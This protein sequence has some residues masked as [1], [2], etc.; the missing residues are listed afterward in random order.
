MLNATAAKK[1]SRNWQQRAAWCLNSDVLYPA[2]MR[3]DRLHFRGAE[4][5][6]GEH[7]I[8]V[9]PLMKAYSVAA[10]SI[11]LVFIFGF[12]PPARAQQVD[13]K[14]L[15]EMQWRNVGP[16]RG[17]RTRAVSGVASQ[18]NVFYVGAVN[19]GVWKRTTLD[20]HGSRFS[21][22]NRPAQLARLKSRLPIREL[23]MSAA[24]KDCIVPICQ[25]A[26][27]FI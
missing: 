23:F 2:R 27:E 5:R 14:L 19:G 7:D 18:P 8:E 1:A 16:F 20:A 13:T 25:S 24:A 6:P 9:D 26:M 4:S 21:T 11:L 10:S 3:C 15:G 12:A 17:G 22:A